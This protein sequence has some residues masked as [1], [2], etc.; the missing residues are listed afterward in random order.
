MSS[1]ASPAAGSAIGRPVAGAIPGVV[2]VNTFREAVRDRILYNLIFFALVM[3]GAAILVGQISI[4]IERLVIINLGLSAISIFGLIMA[5]FIG[6]SLVSKEIEKRTLYSLLSKPIRRWEFLLGRYTGLLLTLVVNT[7]LMTVGLAGAL[8]YVSRHFERGDASILLAVYFILLQLALV[9][10]IALFF[11]CFSTPVLS[12]LYT[13]GIYV[14]GVFA[15]D[16][17]AIG[18]FTRNPAMEAVTRV[19]Y[20]LLPNFHNF[21]IIAVASHGEAVPFSLIWQNTIY[22]ALYAAV[23]LIAAAAVF[24]RRN[25]K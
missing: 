2:A 3:M 22:A 17:H 6:V 18:Q 8:L 9:T 15:N 5:I 10:A 14:A 12:T 24:S 19:I 20:Y 7:S 23:V 25:L 11:S 16:I 13:I 21:N 4:G 1:M